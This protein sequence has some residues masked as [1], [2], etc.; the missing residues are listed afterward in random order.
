MGLSQH[1]PRTTARLY[2]C[3]QPCGMIPPPSAKKYKSDRNLILPRK[4]AD[5]GRFNHTLLFQSCPAPAED[6]SESR[7][8]LGWTLLSFSPLD[9]QH[10]IHMLLLFFGWK[11]YLLA[12]RNL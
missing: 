9:V 7:C 3:L 6:Q 11:W 12:E 2:C 4:K 5:T 8:E 1:P 10:L